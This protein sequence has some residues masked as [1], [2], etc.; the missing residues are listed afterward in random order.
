[1]S[2]DKALGRRIEFDERSREHPVTAIL[3]GRAIKPRSYRWRCQAWLDQGQEGACVGF[4]W[5]HELA[6]R[7][8]EVQAL[9][10]DSAHAVYK[11]AQQ[12]D[13]WPGENYDGT[14]VLAGVKAVQALYPNAIRSYKWAFSPEEIIATLGYYGPVV[15]GINW[16]RDMY[17]PDED[18]WIKVGGQLVGGHAIL[19][20]GVNIR[21]KFVILRNSWGQEW[22]L[23]GDCKLSFDDLATLM[24]LQGEACVPVRRGSSIQS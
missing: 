15:L 14:S 16:Y 20:R 19:A 13:Q 5:S 18:G 3:P 2:E 1:M 17:E 8:V 22:G 11:K 24:K 4:A 6:A 21:G 10:N 12:L 7:P 9:S 23:D